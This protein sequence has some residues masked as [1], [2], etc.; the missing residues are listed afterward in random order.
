MIKYI[1]NQIVKKVKCSVIGDVEI[2]CVYDDDEDESYFNSIDLCTALGFE[3]RNQRAQALRT[4][5]HQD[6]KTSF[7]T[8]LPTLAS[9]YM[10]TPPWTLASE[11]LFT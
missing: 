3:T 5:V 8:I 7:Q 11:V 2:G 4:H 6:D 9:M 10:K 1:M